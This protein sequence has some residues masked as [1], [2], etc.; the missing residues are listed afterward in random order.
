MSRVSTRSKAENLASGSDE[1]VGRPMQAGRD[2][3]LMVAVPRP[4]RVTSEVRTRTTQSPLDHATVAGVLHRYGLEVG[5]ATNASAISRNPV[6]DVTS[7]SGERF[8]LKRYPDRW[9]TNTIRHEHSILVRLSELGFPAVAPI[10]TTSGETWV[11]DTQGRFVL[12]GHVAGRDYSGSFLSPGL[13]SRLM[14]A[15]AGLLADLHSALS[16]FQPAG[17]HHLTRQLDWEGTDSDPLVMLDSLLVDPRMKETDFGWLIENADRIRESL[18]RSRSELADVELVRTVI[19][20]DFGVHNLIVS[21]IDRLVV[22]DFELARPEWRLVDLALTVARLRHR[23]AVIFAEVYRRAAQVPDAEWHIFPTVWQHYHLSGALQGART[24]LD[25]GGSA[26]V[27]SAERRF[28]Q[29]IHPP[30]WISE[31]PST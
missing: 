6:V 5:R 28:R 17:E 23:S 4:G 19:H 21:S 31:W 7:T 11:E 9:G 25:H 12:F 8:V 22:H 3:G 10:R 30:S 18:T 16:G 20:G 26:R 13:R 15:A 1:E 14:S 27:A 2:W 24:H 29:A